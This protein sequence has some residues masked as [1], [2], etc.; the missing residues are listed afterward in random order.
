MALTLCRSPVR[1]SKH[2]PTIS[3]RVT[4]DLH[5]TI[6]M[7]SVEQGRKTGENR[8]VPYKSGHLATLV[9]SRDLCPAGR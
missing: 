7:N 8:E 2:E 9:R 3:H 1:S 4:F 6:A 5:T